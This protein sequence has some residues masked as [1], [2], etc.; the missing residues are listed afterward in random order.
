[1]SLRDRLP[2]LRRYVLIE[3]TAVLVFVSAALLWSLRH[4]LLEVLVSLVLAVIAEPGVKLLIRGKMR[5]SLSVTT[6]FVVILAL[7]VAIVFFLTVPI[8]SAAVRF[9]HQ[10]PHLVSTL[11]QNHGQLAHLLVALHLQSYLHNTS[12]KLT[13]I[14]SSAASPA[15][16]AAKRVVSTV[17][18]LA[19]IFILAVFLSLEGPL[20]IKSVLGLMTPEVAQRAEELRKEMSRSV[21]RY[22][23][24]NLATSAIAGLVIGI[25]LALLG[26][27]YAGVLAVWVG[28]V[29]LLP[30]VGGLLAGVPTVIV[31]LLHSQFDGVVVLIVFLVYQ[32]IENHVLN[33]LVFS[34]A[35][36]LNPLWIL[37]SVLI[38]AQLAHIEGALLAIPVASAAQVVARSIWQD[39]L[40]RR[41]LLLNQAS[42]SSTA[43]LDE[44]RGDDRSTSS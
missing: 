3:V 33:P 14:L 26:V 32:Q 20:I 15:Y 30:L 42:S 31:A 37:L 2:E 23:L 10:L 25:T 1:M 8:Y 44:R 12:I 36:K 28:L 18:N 16:L 43:L 13:Q 7:V 29:D 27:P 6:V 22:L 41:L 9:A 40:S 39:R 24:G 11:S 34:R 19:T 35:V 4:L 38:G 5:R 21:T 17:V